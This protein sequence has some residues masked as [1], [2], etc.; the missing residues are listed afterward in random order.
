MFPRFNILIVLTTLTYFIGFINSENCYI[1]DNA[2]TM[3]PNRTNEYFPTLLVVLNSNE[4]KV[5]RKYENIEDS[6]F[7]TNE[8]AIEWIQRYELNTNYTCF[9]EYNVDVVFMEI[10]AGD[11]NV[12][13]FSLVLAVITL[14]F[15]I[16]ICIFMLIIILC[17]VCIGII[18]CIVNVVNLGVVTATLCLKLKD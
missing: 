10:D 2:I 12:N 9:Y 7:S 16:C 13:I 1:V 11:G 5:A 3:V 8:S 15:T 14:L 17:M 18:W 6:Y 4:T